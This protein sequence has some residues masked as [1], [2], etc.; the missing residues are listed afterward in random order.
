MKNNLYEFTLKILP[1]DGC[2]LPSDMHGAFAPCYASASDYQTAVKKGVAA[3]ASM[4]YTFDNLNGN[5]R[6]IPIENWTTYVQ[7]IWPEFVDSFP[8]QDN[9]S[10]LVDEGAVFFG[11]IVGFQ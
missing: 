6:E 9:I 2:D 3:I 10:S 5:I 8:S 11:P 1:R 7:N 4:H